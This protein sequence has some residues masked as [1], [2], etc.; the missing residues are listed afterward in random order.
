MLTSISVLFAI[1]NALNSSRNDAGQTGWWQ[2][3]NDHISHCYFILHLQ[4]HC[5]DGPA[6]VEHIQQH[7]AVSVDQFTF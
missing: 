6:T 2:L 4:Y 3:S 5:L 7:T 1:K